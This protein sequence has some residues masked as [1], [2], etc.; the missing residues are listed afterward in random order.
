MSRYAEQQQKLDKI[1]NELSNDIWDDGFGGVSDGPTTRSRNDA[2]DFGGLVR[3]EKYSLR[4]KDFTNS[5]FEELAR[6]DPAFKAKLDEQRMDEITNQFKAK[7]PDYL[8]TEKNYAAVCKYIRSAQL[9][10]P[11]MD[12]DDVIA[13]A[14]AA[15]LWTVDNLAEVFKYLKARGRVDLPAEQPKELTNEERLIVTA[16]V[17]NGDP[18]GAITAYLKFSLPSRDVEHMSMERFSTEYPELVSRCVWNVF[19]IMHPELPNEDFR[20]FAGSLKHVALPTI[21][22]LEQTLYLRKEDKFLS[23]NTTP[24]PAPASPSPEPDEPRQLTEDEIRSLSPEELDNLIAK[25]RK[26][27]VRRIYGI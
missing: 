9:K 22:L 3:E 4:P 19:R 5:D 2:Q 27:T 23:R 11:G 21:S 12:V 14:Y 26:E 7:H 15:N 10:D 18:A 25:E 6:R 8:P 24:A 17:R 16:K 1:A 13:E 20:N